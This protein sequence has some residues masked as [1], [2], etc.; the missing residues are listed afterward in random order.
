MDTVICQGCKKEKSIQDF[1]KNKGASTKNGVYHYS[2]CRHCC[3]LKTL[4]KNELI[5]EKGCKDFSEFRKTFTRNQRDKMINERFQQYLEEGKEVEVKIKK[6]IIQSNEIDI[7][8]KKKCSIC[9]LPKPSDQFNTSRRDCCIC[10]TIKRPC[11]KIAAKRKGYSSEEKFIDSVPKEERQKL[12]NEVFKEELIK[13]YSKPKYAEYAEHYSNVFGFSNVV[14]FDDIEDD[15]EDNVEDNIFDIFDNM[16]N[17]DKQIYLETQERYKKEKENQ[18]IIN[19]KKV[20][21]KEGF[22]YIISHPAWPEYFK[23]G[24]AFDLK[25][26]LNNYQTGCPHRA[27]CLKFWQHFEDRI[28]AEKEIHDKLKKHNFKEEWFDCDLDEAIH[29]ITE[30]AQSL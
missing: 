4:A 28:T 11:A 13:E 7:I 21:F 25:K 24:H 23:I 26:R 17:E 27:Y 8:I 6:S 20:D 9:K 10:Q 12:V 18:G 5:K 2:C 19:N 1:R 22:V 3:A 15:I 16:S 14:V 29:A 30:Y